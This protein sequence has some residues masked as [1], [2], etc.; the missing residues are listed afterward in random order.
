MGLSVAYSSLAGV[1]K[2]LGRD[3]EGEAAVRTGLA[4]DAKSFTLNAQ[5]AEYYLK[6]GDLDGTFHHLETSL[7]DKTE[8]INSDLGKFLLLFLS[9]AKI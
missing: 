9:T 5:L 4:G 7:N 6:G 3:E 8:V 2:T 1:L